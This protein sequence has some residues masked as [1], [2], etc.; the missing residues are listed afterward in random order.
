M[1]LVKERLDFDREGDPRQ[2]IGIGHKRPG[3]P[4]TFEEAEVHDDTRDYN[5][6]HGELV[7]KYEATM[8]PELANND[9][10]PYLDEEAQ[11]WLNQYD[12]TGAMAEFFVYMEGFGPAD[13]EKVQM[14]AVNDY[15]TGMTVV[16][17][18]GPDGAVA[19]W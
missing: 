13:G 17:E 7:S 4:K 18:Y 15:D 5:D 11:D 16:F 2:K 8:H 3:Q 19:V 9:D 14:I 1:K 10:I 6:E 12:S